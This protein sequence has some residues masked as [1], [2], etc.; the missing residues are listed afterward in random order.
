MKLAIE[1][2]RVWMEYGIEGAVREL[3]NC[4]FD[5][6][7][8]SFYWDAA[9]ALC[10]DDYLEK[11]VEIR[12]ALKKYGLSCSQAHAPFDF[13]CTMEQEDSCFEY[14]SIKRAIEMAGIIGIDHI[15]VHGI[16]VPEGSVSE[17][18]ME[19][20]YAFYKKLEPFA[21]KAGV[22]IAVENLACAFTYPMLLNQILRRLDSPWFVGLVDVGHAWLRANLQPGSFV[23][24]LDPGSLKGLHIQDNHGQDRGVDEHLAPFLAT[25]DFEDLARALAETGYDGDFTLELPRFLEFYRKQGLLL[26]ALRFSEAVGRKMIAD[27]EALKM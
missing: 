24:Q 15:V 17:Q 9:P 11:A 19:Y 1:S 10:G 8:W 2:Y 18:S 4:G 26:P 5:A 20:N 27:I 25:V 12:D 22:K 6:V 14:V 3:K 16:S 7:D 21:K 23:R 13:L